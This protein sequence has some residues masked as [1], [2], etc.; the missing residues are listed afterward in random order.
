MQAKRARPLKETE[1]REGERAE[2]E[3][4]YVQTKIDLEKRKTAARGGEVREEKRRS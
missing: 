4:R 1:R 3:S 2:G